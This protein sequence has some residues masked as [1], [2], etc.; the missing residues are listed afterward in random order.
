M[1]LDSST[2]AHAHFG[3]FINKLD[4]TC[5]CSHLHVQRTHILGEFSLQRLKSS[6]FERPEM[7]ALI[8]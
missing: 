5:T 1:L 3:D 6:V 7:E 8:H 2:A 4:C